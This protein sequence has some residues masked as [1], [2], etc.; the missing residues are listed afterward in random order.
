VGGDA[1]AAPLEAAK[2]V[3]AEANGIHDEI[4]LT[5]VWAHEIKTFRI[6]TG[7]SEVT[8]LECSG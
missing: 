7:V 3:G 5:T 4:R 6:S 1:A 2:R 8:L